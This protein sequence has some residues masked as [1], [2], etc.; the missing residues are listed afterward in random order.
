MSGSAG[1]GHEQ[2]EDWMA[3]AAAVKVVERLMHVLGYI[4]FLA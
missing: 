3:E 2:D 4:L 1:L